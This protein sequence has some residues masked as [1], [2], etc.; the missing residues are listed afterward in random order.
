MKILRIRLKNLNSLKGDHF[1]DLTAEPL[2]SAGLFAITGPT[3]AGKSTLLDAV[4]LALYG[5]AARYGNESNPENVMSRH[6]GECSAEVEFEVPAGIYRAVWELRRARNKADGA[7]QPPKRYIYNQAGETLAQQIREAELKIEELLGLNHDRFLRSVLLAQGEFARFL[8]ANAN[9]RAE[10]LESLT[11]TEIYSRLGR[12]AFE[13]AN[14]HE[15]DLKDKETSLE[16]IAILEDEEREKLEKD[17]KQ[18][19]VDQRKL[20]GEIESG[21]GMVVKIASLKGARVNEKDASDKQVQIAN[22]TQAAAT[23]LERLRRHR[24]TL[25]FAA[26]LALLESAES[27]MESATEK[28]KKAEENHAAVKTALLKTN[29]LLRLSIAAA[30]VAQR[31]RATKAGITVQREAKTAGDARTWLNEHKHDAVLADQLG[32]LVAAIGD[33]KSGRNSLEG[34]WSDWITVAS[35]ILPVEAQ[36]LP[37]NLETAK[38]VDLK[39]ALDEFLGKAGKRKETLEAKVIDA[40]KLLDLRKDHLEKAKLIAKLED[41]RHDLKSGE[42]CPLCGALE[43]PYAEGAAPSPEI[44][45]LQSEVTKAS[46]KLDAVMEAKRTLSDSIKDLSKDR[47]NLIISVRECEARLKALEKLLQPLSAKAPAHGGEDTLRNG[48]KGREFAYRNQVKAEADATK[49]MTEAE[50]AAREAGKEVVNLE[51]KIG[52]LEPLPP[53]SELKAVAIKHLP[54][55]SDAEEAYSSAIQEEKTTGT[56]ANDRRDD[57]KAA[58]K[59]FGEM[60]K[61]L[62]AMVAGSEFKTLDNLRKAR[63]AADAAKNFESLESSLKQRTNAAEAL[64]KRAQKDINILLETKVLEGEEAESFKARQ[65]QLKKDGDKLIEEQT[66][67]RNQIKT[68]DDNR[69]LRLGKEKEL[70]DDRANLV[71]WKRLRELI[72]SHDGSKFRR[73]AQTIS[74]DILTRHANRHL[75]K[76]SDRYRVC[77]DEK[78]ALNL[79][80]EDLH[81]ASVRRPMASLSGG[82]SFLASLALALGLSDLAGRTV[83][84]DSLFIDEG[85]GSLDPETLEVAIDALESLRQDHKTV[86]IISHVGL[87]K[88][89]ISTQIV[90]EKMAGGVSRLRIVPEEITL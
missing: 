47:G 6:S 25:P 10:L 62:E 46:D 64:L 33:L 43:H 27:A 37:A 17:V 42:P 51:K 45:E 48:L 74:L 83:R 1:V 82:E 41:H 22:D 70:V 35:Q 63:I 71:V 90:V 66:T 19:D 68:D 24:L 72:G 2:A 61:P 18:G 16:Q 36:T 52:K 59:K 69:R 4:T 85:F 50:R 3:G 89:R 67:R 26:D 44:A 79:Q 34:D 73:Y 29:H 11:G 23:D 76:L 55:V 57:L 80:I 38:D 81:Q 40:K 78:E 49:L 86:G 13:K 15:K 53:D 31:E 28:K 14:R 21:A 84:I 5:K 58:V 39:A 87:L 54:P 32:D 9:E 8:K 30:L 12:L 75:V 60:R 56:Q 20:K 77:R 7:L 65:D 88:E